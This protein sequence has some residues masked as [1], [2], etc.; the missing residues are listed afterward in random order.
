MTFEQTNLKGAWVVTLSP[1]N[2]ERGSFARMFCKKDFSEIGFTK[3]FVQLNHSV[4]LS[5]RTFRGLHYQTP[6]Y[7]ETKLI[8]CIRGKIFDVI[9]DIREGSETFLNHFSIELSP[10]NSKMLL[11]PEGFAHGY[12]TLV[13]NSDLIY[14]HTSYYKPG[15]EAALNYMDP[16]LNI[17]L[18]MEPAIISD[19]DKIH[20]FIDNNFTGIK[21]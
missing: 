16:K 4:N 9:V 18:P 8:R 10:E 11:V 20:S 15:F 12:L 19:K 17:Q 13:D 21:I 7:T 1:F 6:P 2:D 3:E 5:K 14:F